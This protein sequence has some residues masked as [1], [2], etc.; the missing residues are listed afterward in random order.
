MFDDGRA[1][2]SGHFLATWPIDHRDAMRALQAVRATSNTLS[3]S[4]ILSPELPSNMALR[5]VWF[6]KE[7]AFLNLEEFEYLA[8]L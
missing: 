2:E 7:C 1:V 5:Y 4:L 3:L 6:L 8:L